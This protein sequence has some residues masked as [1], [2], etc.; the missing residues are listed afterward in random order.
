MEY[1]TTRNE[2]ILP[3]YGRHIQKLVQHIKT[4]EDREERTKAAH[5]L[6][7]IM[8]QVNTNLREN[9][10]YKH[11]LWDHLFIMAD[12]DL[13]V[14]APFEMPDKEVLNRKPDP[15]PYSQGKFKK[16]HYGKII[17]N[18]MDKIDDYPPEEQEVL[19]EL[20]ANQL[21]KSYVKWNKD[22][23]NDDVIISDFIELAEKDVNFKDNIKLVETRNILAKPKK[24][25][26]NRKNRN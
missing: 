5:A 8:A 16:K 20:L 9:G 18:M 13:D 21:K 24:K 14:D 22:S 2:L 12:F 7:P 15:L 17:Q 23:V 10:D 19:V 6:I 25:K 1:N 26:T 4:I 11:K 3:E